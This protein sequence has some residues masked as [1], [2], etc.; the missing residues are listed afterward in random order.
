MNPV[1]PN[2]F[3]SDDPIKRYSSLYI[4]IQWVGV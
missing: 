3:T 1:M 4:L 2:M